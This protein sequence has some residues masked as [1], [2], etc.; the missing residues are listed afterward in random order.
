LKKI[1]LSV[2]IIGLL[3]TMI[4]S[5]A[6]IAAAAYDAHTPNDVHTPSYAHIRSLAAS[7]AACHGTQGNAVSGDKSTVSI[8][9]LAGVSKAD[10][11]SK[12]QAFK[13]GELSATVMHRHAK[14]L[15][16]DEI[17]ALADYFS[18]QVPHRSVSLKPQPLQPDHAN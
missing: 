13:S 1:I 5:A 10:I 17:S 18:M 14:G 6:D 9:A 4:V 7:C 11:I 16:A 2:A 8:S 3:S 15:T 12:L